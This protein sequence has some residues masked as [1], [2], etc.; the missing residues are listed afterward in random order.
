MGID[1]NGLGVG[2][3]FNENESGPALGMILT[4]LKLIF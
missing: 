3:K 4:A 2:N 1:S